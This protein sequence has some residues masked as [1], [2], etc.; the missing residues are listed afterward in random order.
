MEDGFEQA[1]GF[2]LSCAELRFQPVAQGHQFIHFGKRGGVV[3]PK[4][5]EGR[6]ICELPQ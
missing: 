6:A 1:A 5:E 2:R 4:A 3:H